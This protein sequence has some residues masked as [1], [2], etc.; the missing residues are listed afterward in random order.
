MNSI[1]ATEI[2]NDEYAIKILLETL[3]H[4]SNVIELSFKLGIPIA[5]CS[6][7]IKVLKKNRLVHCVYIKLTQYGRTIPVYVSDQKNTYTLL[8][9]FTDELENFVSDLRGTDETQIEVP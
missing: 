1:E 6:K 2:V 3:R 4:P 8:R 7:R 5:D 9:N